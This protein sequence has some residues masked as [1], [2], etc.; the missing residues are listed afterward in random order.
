M[1]V[2][3]KIFAIVLSLVIG[4]SAATMA[5]AG[6]QDSDTGC[7]DAPK[8]TYAV[9]LA[10]VEALYDHEIYL[11]ISS[12]NG[13]PIC[14]FVEILPPKLLER[15]CREEWE[16]K[17]CREDEER[18]E[19]ESEEEE[20]GEEAERDRERGEE[21]EDPDDETEEEREDDSREEDERSE[22]EDGRDEGREEERDRDEYRRQIEGKRFHEKRSFRFNFKEGK[23]RLL[24]FPSSHRCL[25]ATAI[26]TL[27]TQGEVRITPFIHV[28]DTDEYVYPDSEDEEGHYCE[29]ER[30]RGGA[31][32][33]FEDLMDIPDMECDWDYDDAVL[34]IKKLPKEEYRH[35]KEV[36]NEQKEER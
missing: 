16:E 8:T 25:G 4:G 32:Y 17:D 26:I 7:K 33:C 9:H 20:D 6:D 29:A 13:E 11:I 27:Q 19:R 21:E 1:I 30:I 22:E 35:K 14:G 23:G 5:M 24:L 18:E 3:M 36:E 10:E 15:E 28:K 34:F 31:K 2:K 12:D